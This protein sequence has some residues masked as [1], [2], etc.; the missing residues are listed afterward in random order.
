MAGRCV[1]GDVERV[2]PP[3]ATGRAAEPPRYGLLQRREGQVPHRRIVVR[4][5]LDVLGLDQ[6][7]LVPQ[8]RDGGSRG[9]DVVVYLGE[10][11]V[12]PVTG[13]QDGRR[14]DLLVDRRVV[15]LRPVGV[16]GRQDVLAV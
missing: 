16:V 9:R 8:P 11:L 7:G 2:A 4:D 15:Q 14:V 10:R 12:A 3:P 13:R 5:A 1:G 6:R